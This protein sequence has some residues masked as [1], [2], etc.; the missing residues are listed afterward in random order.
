[1]KRSVD[2]I[3]TAHTGSLPRPADLAEMIVAHERG[4]DVPGFDRRVE[5]AVVD[6]VRRQREAGIDIIN[7]GEQG[8]VN[9]VSYFRHR[10]T[11]FEG[12]PTPGGRL[13]LAA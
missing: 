12:E 7:D 4:E 13:Y 6:V 3:L 5:Q 1:M 11:G 10:V 2:R 9:Y 8:K